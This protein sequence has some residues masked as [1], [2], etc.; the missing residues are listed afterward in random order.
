M[1]GLHHED[2][3]SVACH[4]AAV[5]KGKRE[6]LIQGAGHADYLDDVLCSV[7][8][9]GETPKLMGRSL[10]SLQHFQRPDGSGYYWD[11]DK[12]LGVLEELGDVA[13]TIAR[14][15]VSGT[16]PPM[17]KA[18]QYQ[19]GAVFGNFRFPSAAAVGSHWS[20]FPALSQECGRALHFVQ[21]AC[22]PHHVWGVLLWGHQEFEDDLEATWTQ[23]RDE[24]KT[25]GQ[26]ATFC[27]AVREALAT[28][29]AKTV[30]DLIKSNAAWCASW[31]G[32]VHRLEECNTTDMLAVCIRAVASSVAAIN[33]MK[34]EA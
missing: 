2:L 1:N 12:S 13:T 29:K 15:H 24:L 23:H 16:T 6:E 18:M 19:P 5:P 34:G 22:V 3:T 20:T 21:D 25:T 31:F 11:A 27:E 17:R 30:E 14:A 10:T 28:L 33:L 4:L 7:P 8:F 26:E 9:E 32:Q